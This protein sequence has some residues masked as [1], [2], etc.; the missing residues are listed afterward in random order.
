VG[1]GSIT[2]P[3]GRAIERVYADLQVAAPLLYEEPIVADLH[4]FFLAASDKAELQTIP[5]EPLAAVLPA[6]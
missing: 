2:L 3:D 4:R 6:I 5:S 1:A